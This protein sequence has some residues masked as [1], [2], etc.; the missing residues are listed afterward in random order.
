MPGLL[1]VSLRA[2]N[3]DLSA[4]EFLPGVECLVE[5]AQ[6]HGQDMVTFRVLIRLSFWWP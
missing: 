6:Q 4:N 5:L 3:P 1:L 2:S